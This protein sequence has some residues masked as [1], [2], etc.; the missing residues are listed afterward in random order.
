[1]A[2]AGSALR[3]YSDYLV[4]RLCFEIRYGASASS[5][6]VLHG[7]FAAGEPAGLAPY[8]HELLTS[9]LATSARP[10][11]LWAIQAR[12]SGSIRDLR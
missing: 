2:P 3:R 11:P 9:V 7:L 4:D 10:L 6:A 8:V 1:M 5:A 12:R